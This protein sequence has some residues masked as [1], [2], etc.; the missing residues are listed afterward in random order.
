MSI[1]LIAIFFLTED[2]NDVFSVLSNPGRNYVQ[3]TFYITAV[4]QFFTTLTFSLIGLL[5]PR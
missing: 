4:P 3:F 5:R 2:G 1:V